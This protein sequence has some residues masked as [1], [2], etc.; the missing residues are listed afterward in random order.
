[1]KL[2]KFLVIGLTMSVVIPGVS[3]FAATLSPTWIDDNTQI[4]GTLNKV[5]SG[6]AKATTKIITSKSGD[7]AGAGLQY[8]DGNG[9]YF[10]LGGSYTGK[11]ASYQ[12][13]HKNA[14][15]FDSVHTT[16]KSGKSKALHITM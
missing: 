2:K 11:S 7:V 3:A 9:N 15:G 1:M 4:S 8:Y 14:R 16:S 10:Y 5:S 12:D 6:V 13:G